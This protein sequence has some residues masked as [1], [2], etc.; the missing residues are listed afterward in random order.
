MNIIDAKNISKSYEKNKRIKAVIK[1]ISLKIKE[2]SFVVIIGPSGSGKTTLLNLLSGVIPISSGELFVNNVNLTELDKESLVKFRKEN[3][4]FVFQNPNL[5]SYLTVIQNIEMG[6][7]LSDNPLDINEI[8]KLMNLE[9]LVNKYPNN[10]SGG[11]QHKVS[12]ARALIKNPKV[13][14]LDEPTISLDNISSKKILSL[15][16]SINEKYKTTI[17]L[18]THDRKI[19]ELSDKVIELKDGKIILKTVNKIK[20]DKSILE[21]AKWFY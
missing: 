18:V 5:I 1:N 11:E 13:L 20:K 10:L 2:G 3:I 14:F 16:L 7:Y 21:K 19:K 4:S 17:I 8:I 12:I 6:K 9:K 15:L